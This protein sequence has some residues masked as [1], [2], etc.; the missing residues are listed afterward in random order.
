MA[1][2]VLM[3]SIVIFNL[4]SSHT[5]GLDLSNWMKE[6][7]DI[8]FNRSLSDLTILG[9]HD[10]GA[11]NLSQ[12]EMPTYEPEYIEVL[13]YVGEILGLPV[14]DVIT[15]WGKAQPSNLYDQM[16]AGV[17]YIDLRCGW[18][19]IP[20]E[21]VTFHWET[22]NTIQ[23]LMDDVASFLKSHPQEIVLIEA[24]HLEGHKVDDAKLTKLV[25]IFQTTFGNGTG[26]GLFPRMKGNEHYLPSYGEMITKGY[27][28]FLSLENDEIASKYDNIQFESSF[29]N[30]YADSDNI[31]FMM[32]FNDEQVD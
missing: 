8:L 4:L 14:E 18:L 7:S 11:Y 10:S 25:D 21:W 26:I 15:L 12:R 22:G 6:K 16:M 30:T 9:T 23:T 3:G 31:T 1:N 20:G 28:V 29:E 27:R 2:T 5:V 19:E 24:S 13:A 32:E 17:R